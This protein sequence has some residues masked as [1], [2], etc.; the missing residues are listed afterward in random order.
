M[1]PD[2][3]KS[4]LV[5]FPPFGAVRGAKEKRACGLQAHWPPL[6]LRVQVSFPS[7]GTNE[8]QRSDQHMCE[9]CPQ[10]TL[11]EMCT[12]CQ[13]LKG[14]PR[15]HALVLPNNKARFPHRGCNQVVGVLSCAIHF[16][17]RSFFP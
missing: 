10:G 13:Q 2:M 9:C 17:S 1:N 11:G 14:T 6:C 12:P 16:A 15:W 5:G 8:P 3:L 7:V 4:C